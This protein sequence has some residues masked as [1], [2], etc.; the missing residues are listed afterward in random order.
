MF[1]HTHIIFCMKLLFVEP[2][3]PIYPL[4]GGVRSSSIDIYITLSSHNISVYM[5]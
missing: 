3:V 1:K 4:G 2:V 5:F